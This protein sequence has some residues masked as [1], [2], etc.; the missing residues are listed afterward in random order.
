MSRSGRL[1][2]RL[3]DINKSVLIFGTTKHFACSFMFWKYCPWYQTDKEIFYR[4]QFVYIKRTSTLH[5]EQKQ[6]Q[7]RQH[8][9]ENNR[10]YGIEQ[11]KPRG[12]KNRG[13]NNESQQNDKTSKKILPD[14][15]T[16]RQSTKRHRLTNTTVHI[17]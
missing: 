16:A 7:K 2:A 4:N 17:Q 5:S 1:L 10:I 14:D 8:P 11:D 3:D 6:W 12:M 13:Q 15:N 9:R